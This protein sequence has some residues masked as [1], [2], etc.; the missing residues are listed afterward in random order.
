MKNLN[1]RIYCVPLPDAP[2][3]SRTLLIFGTEDKYLTVKAAQDSA[4]YVDNFQLELLEG[5]RILR[6][7]ALMH[8]KTSENASFFLCEGN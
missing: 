5:V 4:A 8:L 1:V 7:H 3:Q 2:A 6:L